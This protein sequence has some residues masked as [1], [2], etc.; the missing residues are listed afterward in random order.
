[1][2]RRGWIRC[3]TASLCLSAR[4]ARSRVHASPIRICKGEGEGRERESGEI[5]VIPLRFRGFHDHGNDK[6]SPPPLSFSSFSLAAP[7]TA[8]PRGPGDTY[9]VTM[10]GGMRCWCTLIP[11]EVYTASVAEI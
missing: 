11:G 7:P 6:R 10:F 1:M 3:L 5:P 2:P 8:S 4:G 9:S